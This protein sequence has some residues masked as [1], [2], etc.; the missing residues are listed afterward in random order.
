MNVGKQKR[1]SKMRLGWAVALLILALIISPSAAQGQKVH[2][3]GALVADDQFIP[4]VDGF[5]QRMTELGYLEGKNVIYDL[6][7]SKGDQDLLRKMAETLVQQK[8]DLIVTSSTTATVPVAKLTPA[9]AF[10]SSFS[11]PEIR[12]V[13]SRAMPVQVTISQAYPARQ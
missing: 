4:A 3:I 10:L 11:A 12:C 8:P 6:H 1:G 13:W 9:P 7:N 5:K 2:R